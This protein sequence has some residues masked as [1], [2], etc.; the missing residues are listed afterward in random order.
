MS[1]GVKLSG[2]ALDALRAS[3]LYPGFDYAKTL[4]E[5]VNVYK[6]EGV[7]DFLKGATDEKEGSAGNISKLKHGKSI[8]SHPLGELIYILY[9]ET[10]NQYPED[11]VKKLVPSRKPPPKNFQ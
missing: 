3:K 1:E 7:V 9:V 4:T 11:Y 6:T 10:F 5:L 2:K 8:P